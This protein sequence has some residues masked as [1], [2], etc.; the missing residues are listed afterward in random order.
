MADPFHEGEH[1]MQQQAGTAEMAAKIGPT[2]RAEIG[3]RSREFLAAQPFAVLASRDGGGRMWASVV[4][5]APGFLTAADARTLAIAAV[6]LAGDPLAA[7]LAAGAPLGVLILDPATRRRLRV[8][9]VV[10]AAEPP[11]R[12]AVRELFGNCPK[13]IQQ[14][15]L[16]PAPAGDGPTRSAAEL[17]AAQ[18]QRIAGADTFF[19]ASQHPRAGLDASHR[20]GHPG[21]VDVVDAGHLAWP[22]YAGNGMF[23]TL[24]NLTRAPR[25]GL[26]FID[27]ASGD[28]LQ[29]TGRG[30]I[31]LDP[32]RARRYRGAQR[33]VHF[34]VDEVRDTPGAVPLRAGPPAYSPHNP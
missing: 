13:Y 25:A 21:F 22:D 18:R 19:I 23:Q 4:A 31:D 28:M 2:I 11:I 33:V 34:A 16:R 24:G 8:N 29:L 17:S 9:G 15:E 20:G 14:R 32:A 10:A 26:L 6:P 5:G 12:L 27:F 1:A 7:T 30:S 3:S